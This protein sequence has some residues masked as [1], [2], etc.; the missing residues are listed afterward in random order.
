[1]FCAP[2]FIKTLKEIAGEVGLIY[3]MGRFKAPVLHVK[4]RYVSF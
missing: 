3:E 1:V 2:N 4:E